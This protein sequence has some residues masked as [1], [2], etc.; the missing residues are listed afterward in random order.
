MGD[1]QTFFSIPDFTVVDG[2]ALVQGLY[3]ELVIL[4]GRIT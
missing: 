3:M 1:Q 4:A 2:L